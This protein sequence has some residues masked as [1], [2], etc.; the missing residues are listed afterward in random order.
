MSLRFSSFST[1]ISSLIILFRLFYE[2]NQFNQHRI[3]A[4]VEVV[5]LQVIQSFR[6]SSLSM[7]NL[8]GTVIVDKCPNERS[9]W[10]H[11]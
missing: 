5:I 8:A 4:I 6:I 3:V 2:P 7:D 11:K 9:E 1:H 10:C